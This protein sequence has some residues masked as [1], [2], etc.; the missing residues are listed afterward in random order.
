MVFFHKINSFSYA[1]L[2]PQRVSWSSRNER[3][4]T[5]GGRHYGTDTPEVYSRLLWV[6]RDCYLLGGKSQNFLLSPFIG[7]F[8]LSL[9]ASSSDIDIEGATQHLRDILKLDCHGNGTGKPDRN[10]KPA[11]PV[12]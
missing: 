11:A 8:S 5:A 9:M 7:H 10:R 1:V 3:T 12:V 4:E 6:N 2:N